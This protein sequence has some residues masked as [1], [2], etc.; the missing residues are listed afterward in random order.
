MYCTV[1]GTARKRHMLYTH[2]HPFTQKMGRR[3]ILNGDTLCINVLHEYYAKV[4]ST[5]LSSKKHFLARRLENI[6]G[7]LTFPGLRKKFILSIQIMVG[8]VRPLFLKG[9]TASG[10]QERLAT[11]IACVLYTPH[12]PHLHIHLHSINT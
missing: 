10:I 8:L 3:G 7:L 5:D 11:T 4:Y 1:S 2:S 6:R 12:E 9:G